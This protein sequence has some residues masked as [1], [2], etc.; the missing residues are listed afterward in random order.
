MVPW[1]GIDRAGPLLAVR[2]AGFG[3]GEGNIILVQDTVQQGAARQ[4]AATCAM[5]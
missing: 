1:I 3:R 4:R 5:A 2:S